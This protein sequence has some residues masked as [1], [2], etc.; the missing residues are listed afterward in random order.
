MDPKDLSHTVSYSNYLIL[1]VFCLFSFAGGIWFGKQSQ[2]SSK[3]T[4]PTETHK[5][6]REDSKES[7][8]LDSSIYSFSGEKYACDTDRAYHQLTR[9]HQRNL[10]LATKKT[11]QSNR[12]RTET[13]IRKSG[14]AAA[15]ESAFRLCLRDMMPELLAHWDHDKDKNSLKQNSWDDSNEESIDGIT[16]SVLIETAEALE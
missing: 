10:D 15:A 9:L 2:L 5:I 4:L 16:K 13:I 11:S 3:N 12:A 8:F 7:T 1:T 14:Q 6:A